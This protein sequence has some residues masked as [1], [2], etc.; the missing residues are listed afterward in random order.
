M[1]AKARA[2][3]EGLLDR[4]GTIGGVVSAELHETDEGD[5]AELRARAV[6]IAARSLIAL[7][8]KESFCATAVSPGDPKLGEYLRLQLAVHSDERLLAIFVDQQSRYLHDE[9]IC[10][11]HVGQAL[12]PVRILVKRAIDLGASGILLAHNHPSNDPTP[13][14]SDIQATDDLRQFLSPI[15]ITLLDHLVVTR[16][17]IYSIKNGAS[18]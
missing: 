3:A 11:G 10:R 14:Q 7:A 6:I 13:S 4:Y 9:I 18:L 5:E 16:Q 15:E 2:I 8:L 1:G 17:V 12:I